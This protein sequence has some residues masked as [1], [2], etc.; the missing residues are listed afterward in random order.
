[1]VQFLLPGAIDSFFIFL[2]AFVYNI[3]IYLYSCILLRRNLLP[4]DCGCD[5]RGKRIIGDSRGFDG[6][7]LALLTGIAMGQILNRPQEALY[8]TVGANFGT[9]IS[10]FIKRRLNYKNGESFYFIDNVD[11]I[12]GAFLLYSSRFDASLEIFCWGVLLYGS[13]HYFGNLLF[14][15]YLERNL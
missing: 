5:Y 3:S 12:L 10:S 13:M 1:M 14:R 2:P 11:F 9:I 8:V 15:G 6:I 7:F 4:L